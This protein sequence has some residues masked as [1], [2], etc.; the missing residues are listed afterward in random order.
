MCKG[1]SQ[2]AKRSILQEISAEEEKAL[3]E[4]E[5]FE[6]EQSALREFSQVQAEQEGEKTRL[7][8]AASEQALE[9]VKKYWK[10]SE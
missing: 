2:G 7:L 8:D 10:A 5:E 4:E 3:Q 1:L 6:R 9:L